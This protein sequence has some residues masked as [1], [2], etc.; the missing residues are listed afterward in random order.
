MP[1]WGLGGMGKGLLLS[2]RNNKRGFTHNAICVD[3]VL[4]PFCSEKRRPAVSRRDICEGYNE[5]CQGVND[6]VR[7]SVG[8]GA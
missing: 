6:V 2:S 5:G 7:G 1:S 3:V 8:G 4:M